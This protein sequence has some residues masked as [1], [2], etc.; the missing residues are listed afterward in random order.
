M[1]TGGKLKPL[2]SRRLHTSACDASDK[3]NIV[4]AFETGWTGRSSTSTS[5]RQASL[6]SQGAVRYN[7]PQGD[8][9]CPIC[10]VPAT[11]KHIV[12]L[13]KWRHDKGHCRFHGLRGSTILTKTLYGP[14][15]GSTKSSTSTRPAAPHF[16]HGLWQNL[17]A[18]DL[19]GCHD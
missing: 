18:Q 14:E 15:G 16:G 13:C 7:N 17:E 4:S 6:C 19:A 2:C 9:L 3:D 8:E 10:K 5:A 11:S 12:W 1:T